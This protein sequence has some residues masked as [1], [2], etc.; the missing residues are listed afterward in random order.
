MPSSPCLP[1]GAGKRRCEPFLSPLP[2]PHP[3]LACG[4]RRA[5]AARHAACTPPSS[6]RGS[7]RLAARA[8]NLLLLPSRPPASWLLLG[9]ACICATGI[10][11]A[12]PRL[13]GLCAVQPCLCACRLPVGARARPFSSCQR[14]AARRSARVLFF[15]ETFCASPLLVLH[16]TAVLFRYVVSS[17]G[18]RACKRRVTLKGVLKLC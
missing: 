16:C 3:S 13:P 7:T 15:R 5:R 11:N 9:A 14:G 12:G 17:R 4:L 10:L 18:T 8:P 6:P 1:A 2:A